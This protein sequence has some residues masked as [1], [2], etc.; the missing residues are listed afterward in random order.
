M[1]DQTVTIHVR[2]QITDESDRALR[3]IRHMTGVSVVDEEYGGCFGVNLATAIE[4]LCENH[5]WTLIAV[6]E[7]RVDRALRLQAAYVAARAALLA[8]TGEFKDAEWREYIERQK[9]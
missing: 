2:S 4:T 7:S 3:V 1:I 5:G 6:N 9:R 8:T